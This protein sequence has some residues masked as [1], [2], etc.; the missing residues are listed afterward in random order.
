MLI[1]I[2]KSNQG[3]G[4]SLVLMT[5]YQDN[6]DIKEVG[7]LEARSILQCET[8]QWH[9]FLTQAFR[10]YENPSRVSCF[11]VGTL[12]TSTIPR[13]IHD[14]PSP[15]EVDGEQE[16]EVENILDSIIS[17]CQFQYLN[18]WNGYDVSERTWELIK[19]L[20]NTMEKVHE[21]HEWYPNK[22]KFIPH[23]TWH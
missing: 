5:T 13:R 21:F 11:L 18:H 3:R 17:N 20:L 1:N 10:F 19:N 12:P 14:P 16:Y 7:L 9:Y 23:G 6:K 4:P 2:R 15:I 8:N 22:P